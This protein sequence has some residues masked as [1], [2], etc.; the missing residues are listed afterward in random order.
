MKTPE[1]INLLSEFEADV[2]SLDASALRL[3]VS[4]AT[5]RNWLKTGYLRSGRLGGI[6]LDSIKFFQNEVAGKEKLNQRANKSLK[7]FHNHDSVT[8]AFIGRA[9]SGDGV[10]SSLG[11]EYQSSLSDSFRNTEGIYYTASAVV[12]ELFTEPECDFEQSTFCDPCCGSGNFII[13]ALELGFKPENIYGYDVD[14]VAIEITKARIREFCGHESSNI[15]E[16]DFLQIASGDNACRFDFIYTNPPWGKKLPK[17][18]KEYLGNRLKAGS[19]IDTSS[20]FFFAC[21]ECLNENGTLGLLLPESFF[22]ISAFES[23]RLKSLSF[24]ITRL[25]DFGRPFKGLVTKAQ[26]IVLTK[27]PANPTDKVNCESSG[28]C[29]VRPVTSFSCNPKSILNLHCDQESADTLEYLFS[30][31]HVTLNG[32]AS[33][34]LGIVTGNNEKFIQP[35]KRDGYI[36]VFKGADIFQNELKQPSSYIPADLGLYQQVAPRQLYEA[37]EKLIYKFISSRLC[38][39]HDTNQRYVLNSANMLIP[40][41][42]FPVSTKVLGELLSSD[43]MNWIFTCIFNTAKILR[44][45]LEAL[46][47]YTQF[48]GGT[49]KFCECSYL[50]NLN[51]E[52]KT[53]GTYRIKR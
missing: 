16:A 32:Q 33:W 43:F 35:S 38:F 25:V 41:E 26:A 24:S 27:K 9:K 52:K 10:N 31:P 22:N 4:S 5:I 50:N 37:K 2:V 40:N 28:N 11:E 49:Q 15:R 39:F 34:G 47:I 17:E 23:A 51:I 1:Q 8:S 21:L 3:G 20:L 53:N 30:I 36:P 19:S 48:L 7:D 29:V 46:P 45:D 14:P 12:L 18:E 42:N 44:G 13:R 6:T